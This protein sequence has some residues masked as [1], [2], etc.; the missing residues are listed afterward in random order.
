MVSFVE[1]S[2]SVFSL[3]ISVFVP[4]S[5]QREQLYAN[6]LSRC[7][8]AHQDSLNNNIQIIIFWIS[9]FS[10]FFSVFSFIML[11]R[12]LWRRQFHCSYRD[13]DQH[14]KPGGLCLPAGLLINRLFDCMCGTETVSAA[15]W[16][17]CSSVTSYDVRHL[18]VTKIPHE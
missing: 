7:S 11:T 5:K 2:D 12:C 17:A 8:T 16:D 18:S 13:A 14:C 1:P 10:V 3:S 15:C 6:W 9:T 4:S